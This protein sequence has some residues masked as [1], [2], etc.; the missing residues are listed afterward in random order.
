[1]KMNSKE[2]TLKY[3][4]SWQEPADFEELSS[5]LAE[6]FSIDA[7]IFTFNSKKEFVQFLKSNPTPWKEV[8]LLSSVF[9]EKNTSILYEGVNT[10]NNKKMRVAEHIQFTADGVISEI[11]TVITQLD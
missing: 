6:E 2:I 10:A 7:G 11:M 9:S 4:N 3:F 5:Y 1:M 8:K